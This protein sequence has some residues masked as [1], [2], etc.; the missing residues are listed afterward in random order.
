MI[1]LTYS[2]VIY[3]KYTICTAYTQK[4]QLYYTILYKK[5]HYCEENHYHR[6][7]QNY[8][9]PAAVYNNP[10][11]AEWNRQPTMWYTRAECIRSENSRVYR[12]A[13][14]HIIILIGVW[15]VWLMWSPKGLLDCRKCWSL[16]ISIPRS[17]Q[18][19]VR[20]YSCA[21]FTDAP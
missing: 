9:K 8:T 21:V 1:F 15:C 13:L 16:V 19:L 12:V 18:A 17:F 2:Q 14:F 6:D 10:S 5:N 7:N 11:H 20:S 3:H 4:P